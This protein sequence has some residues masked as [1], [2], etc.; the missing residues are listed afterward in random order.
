MTVKELIERLTAY[1]PDLEVVYAWD[2]NYS[3]PDNFT[4]DETEFGKVLC[5]GEENW[6][7]Y[8]DRKRDE[9]EAKK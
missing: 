5:I 6:G 2:G 7:S 1:D 8:G 4:I 9:A 3:D